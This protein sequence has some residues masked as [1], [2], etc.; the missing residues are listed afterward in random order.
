MLKANFNQDYLTGIYLTVKNAK[1]E[2]TSSD[3]YDTLVN[4]KVA[5]LVRLRQNLYE[6]ECKI[7]SADS[8]DIVS[9]VEIALIR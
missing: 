6:S 1:K 4:A 9:E 3:E 2:I 7:K 8:L 5:D